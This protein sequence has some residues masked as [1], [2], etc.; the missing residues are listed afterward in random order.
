MPYASS[1]PPSSPAYFVGGTQATFE[2]ASGDDSHPEEV[3]R[4]LPLQVYMAAPVGPAAETAV[5]TAAS[6]SA[7]PP[8]QR[9]YPFTV[10]L[11]NERTQLHITQAMGEKAIK[12]IVDGAPAEDATPE[13]LQCYQYLL[14][15]ES[16]KLK[17]Q[18]RIL[19]ERRRQASIS[20]ARR[21]D[22]SV[23]SSGRSQP[24]RDRPRYLRILEGARTTVT[25]NLENSF[26]SLD[27]GGIPIPKTATGA[28]M[29]V[30]TYLQATQPP[31]NDP[32]AAL[33]RQQ[34][35]FVSMAGAEQFQK[36]HHNQ[37]QL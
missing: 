17:E 11:Q 29:S 22:L 32:R 18:E 14:W 37:L 31:E 21:A 24:S 2:S 34:I 16:I 6:P 8:E 20:R 35:K 27:D 4:T 9:V 1:T 28:L 15:Q 7:P 36:N 19:A 25:R 30:A 26:M 12:A 33:H 13:D 23:Q 5:I 3:P 10:T